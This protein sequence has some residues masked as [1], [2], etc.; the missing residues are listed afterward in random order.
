MKHIRPI[1]GHQDDFPEYYYGGFEQF[2]GSFKRK[3]GVI[4]LKSPLMLFPVRDLEPVD[5]DTNVKEIP[6]LA[7][8]ADNLFVCVDHFKNN[9]PSEK[10]VEKR[11]LSSFSI[12][13]I[14]Y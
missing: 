11:V 7:E 14:N 12:V 5:K 2:W 1:I 10:N 3:S 8:F 13:Y 9:N 6:I 4:G